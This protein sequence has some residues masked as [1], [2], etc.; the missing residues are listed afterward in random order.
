MIAITEK[1]G[2]TEV[3][4]L[5]A[6][7]A[8]KAMRFFPRWTRRVSITRGQLSAH[9]SDDIRRNTTPFYLPHS[10]NMACYSRVS[11]DYSAAKP[12]RSENWEALRLDH[13]HIWKWISKWMSPNI[14]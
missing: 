3:S 13:F 2:R 9:S 4:A 7:T 1:V 12:I 6:M 8:Q 10:T 11:K 5:R 14:V